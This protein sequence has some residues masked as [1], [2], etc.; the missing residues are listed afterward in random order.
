LKINA[1]FGLCLRLAL[2][3][4]VEYA[5]ELM[6]RLSSEIG[7]D[8]VSEIKTADQS[9]EEGLYKQRERVKVLEKK[10]K[11]AEAEDLLSLIDM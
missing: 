5:F 8:L 11:K 2:D 4:Q 6:D 9:T 1:E 3:K 10:L 7:K